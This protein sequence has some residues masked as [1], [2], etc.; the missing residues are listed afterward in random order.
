MKRLTVC[1]GD[2]V[3]VPETRVACGRCD[4]RTRYRKVS[5]RTVACERCG[6]RYNR[7]ALVDAE[8]T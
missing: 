2:V 8:D 4:E 7:E 3:D 5:A 6:T 1:N